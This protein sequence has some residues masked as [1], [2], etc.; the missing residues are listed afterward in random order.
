MNKDLFFVLFLIAWA[1]VGGIDV[2][3][4]HFCD[5][6]FISVFFLFLMVLYLVFTG[7]RNTLKQQVKGK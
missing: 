6:S 5:P 4:Y 1:I 7:I 2:F 3:V